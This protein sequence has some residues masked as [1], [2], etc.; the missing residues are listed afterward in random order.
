[1]TYKFFFR[2]GVE[3]NYSLL[4]A[5]LEDDL[6]ILILL[7]LALQPGNLCILDGHSTHTHCYIVKPLVLNF[8]YLQSSDQ[9]H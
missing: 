9:Q 3:T 6:P 5:C 1:M 8:Q 7:S 2:V 4:A